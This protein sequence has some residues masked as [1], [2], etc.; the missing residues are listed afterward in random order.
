[1]NRGMSEH[2]ILADMSYDS[3]M[4]DRPYLKGRFGS[5][6]YI[7][8]EVYRDESGWWDRNPTN[9][10]PAAPAAAAAAV[11]AAISDPE[12]VIR[13]AEELRDSGEVQLAMHIIDLLALTDA[14]DDVSKRARTLKAQLCRL[15]AKQVK[16]YVSKILL[17]TSAMLL[18]RGT[19]SWTVVAKDL[20]K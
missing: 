4:L 10:N 6:D 12:A 2:E 19:T 18:E 15:R 1:M 16:P 17:E 5:P 8:R 9:L 14:E 11:R 13:K 7:V 20:S 3:P